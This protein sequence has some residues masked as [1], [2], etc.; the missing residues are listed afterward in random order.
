L[1]VLGLSAL[2]VALRLGRRPLGATWLELAGVA[3]L[4]GA[5][6][7]MSFFL[8]ALVFPENDPVQGRLRAAVI[9]GSLLSVLAGG[10]VLRR[11]QALRDENPVDVT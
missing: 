3:L 2:A 7:T 10:I 9:V 1:G 4:C 8:G 6:F 5:G 11:A